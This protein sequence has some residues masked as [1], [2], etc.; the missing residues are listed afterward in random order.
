MKSMIP[1]ALLSALLPLAA[2]AATTDPVGYVTQSL[3]QGFNLVGITV[4]SATEVSGQPESVAGNTFTDNDVDFTAALAA[5]TTYI[6]EITAGPG[7]G[8]I[9]EVTAWT[10]NSLTTP[11]DLTVFGVGPSSSFTLRKAQ[12]LEEI[13]GT[14]ESVL[15][16]AFNIGSADVV[17][18]PDGSGNYDRFF[19]HSSNAWRSASNVN[20]PNIPVVYTDGVLIEKKDVGTVQL[21]LE[22]E[23]KTAA[24]SVP[25]INGF[26]VISVVYPAGATLQNIGL[27]N[28]VKA[29]FNI[30][31]ADVI[32][33]PTGPG[34]FAR[35][36]RHSS[37][38]WRNDSNVNVTAPVPLPSALL[39][40]R[41]DPAA[42]FQISPPSSW[43]L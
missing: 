19:L 34:T 28:S 14:S 2:S 7:A 23:V 42:N 12:T 1:F 11:V 25:V 40:E 33:V 21:V 36:F 31:S 13:F 9:Q 10:T 4:H 32:W 38:N 29:A 27:E 41:K 8:L 15:K 18:V 22:G 26:N 24:T 30:G 35:Y 17:W 43:N 3:S 16:K 39:I 6:L 5:G 37:G 20:A